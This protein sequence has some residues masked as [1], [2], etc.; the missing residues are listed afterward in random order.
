[1]KG[2]MPTIELNLIIVL[3]AMCPK[4]TLACIKASGTGFQM[5]LRPDTKKQH[6]KQFR[7]FGLVQNIQFVGPVSRFRRHMSGT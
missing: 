7:N 3:A 1:M 6:A 5:L 4:H 2:A